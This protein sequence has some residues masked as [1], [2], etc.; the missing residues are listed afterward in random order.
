MKPLKKHVCTKNYNNS[1]LSN[2]SAEIIGEPKVKKCIPAATIIRAKSAAKKFLLHEKI[3]YFQIFL[4]VI[5]IKT[6]R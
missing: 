1:S 6:F 4:L 2:H 3:Y 5:L